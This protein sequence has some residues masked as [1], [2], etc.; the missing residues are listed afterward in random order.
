[1]VL[2]GYRLDRRDGIDT[3]DA[4]IDDDGRQVRI[5]GR[6]EGAIEAFIDGWNRH[7]GSRVNVIDYSEHA[8]GEGT[9][10]EAAAYTLLNID[11]QRSAGAAINRDSVSASL[12]ALLAALNRSRQLQQAA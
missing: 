7:F 6:G 2:T 9:T 10:A 3:I 8:V 12:G 11:G 4:G 1:V 5:S